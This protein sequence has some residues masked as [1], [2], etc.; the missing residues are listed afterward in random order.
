MDL[1]FLASFSHTFCI[2]VDH[3]R[4]EACL[5][6]NEKFMTTQLSFGFVELLDWEHS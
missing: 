4:K 3:I 1:P 6:L 2:I 5:D